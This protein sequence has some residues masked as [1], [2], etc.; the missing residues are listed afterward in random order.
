MAWCV[1]E[2]DDRQLWVVIQ[3]ARSGRS[4][5]ATN[6][7]KVG[8]TTRHPQR[9]PV[10]LLEIDHLLAEDDHLRVLL[11]G[12]IVQRDRDAVGVSGCASSPILEDGRR[13]VS[14]AV[15]DRLCGAGGLG[16]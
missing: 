7:G 13:I 4:R 15:V 1:F 12:A 2:E 14:P 16:G 11:V 6:A 10:C 9:P 8:A 5:A 3:P